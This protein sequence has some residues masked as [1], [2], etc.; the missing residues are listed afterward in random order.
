MGNKIGKR[1]VAVDEQFTKPQG[2]YEHHEIDLRRLR[3]LILDGKLSPCYN[4]AEEGGVDLEECPIC[5]L[6]NPWSLAACPG[7]LPGFQI[8]ILPGRPC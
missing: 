6:V 1:K 5:L 4:G 8:N 7:S 2:L 3:K